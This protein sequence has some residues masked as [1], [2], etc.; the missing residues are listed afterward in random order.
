MRD[1]YG[2]LLASHRPLPKSVTLHAQDTFT[3]I[4]YHHMHKF[5]VQHTSSIIIQF[6][7][8]DVRMKRSLIN[9]MNDFNSYNAH[10]EVR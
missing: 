10:S 1:T 9:V 2:T 6:Q 3:V 7:M 4:R 8:E 5:Y